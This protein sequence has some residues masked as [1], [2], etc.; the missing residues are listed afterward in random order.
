MTIEKELNEILRILKDYEKRICVLENVKRPVKTAHGPTE[1]KDSNE[2]ILG[3]VNKIGEC[4]E[5]DAIQRNILD[6]KSMEGKILLCFFIANK[7]FKNAWLKTGEIEKI[8]SD[9][10][11]K[12]DARN[13]TNKIKELRQLLESGAARKKGQ[14]TPYR[15]NRN[16]IKRF[17]IIL[18]DKK[19]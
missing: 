12:I 7:Y 9:L 6:K 19:N 18:G 1:T 3:I 5:S 10:G 8:T 13:V 17:Y 16:G 15:L 4:E 11:V 14:P 2:L